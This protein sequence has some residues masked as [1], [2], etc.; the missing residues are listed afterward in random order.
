MTVSDRYLPLA[1]APIDASHPKIAGRTIIDPSA[2]WYWPPAALV[3]DSHGEGSIAELLSG[4]REEGRRK[5]PGPRPAMML[6]WNGGRATLT[7]LRLRETY[8]DAY[9]VGG[10]AFLL[11]GVWRRYYAD[12]DEQSAR[13]L[14]TRDFGSLLQ[15]DTTVVL[16]DDRPMIERRV[17]VDA[18]EIDAP[19]LCATPNEAGH[20][21]LW[22]LHALPLVV[23]FQAHPGRYEKL[24]VTGTNP[25]LQ[26]MLAWLGMRDENLLLHDVSRAY[27][28]RD[29]DRYRESRYFFYVNKSHRR[30]FQRLALRAS[31]AAG[32]P[33]RRIFVSRL[34]HTRSC[35]YRSLLNE[36]AL[37]DA[38]RPLGFE[39]VEPELLSPA[40][41]IRTF[42]GADVVVG[43]GGGAMF[44][45]VFCKP[46]TRVLSIESS[47]THLAAH[48]SLFA[49]LGL[50]YGFL[51]GH[52]D[53]S[54]PR[55]TQKRWA[56]DVEAAAAHVARF[57]AL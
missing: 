47:S 22:L 27:R 26:A 10:D 55:V 40:E 11:D 42:A 20:W 50:R 1:F 35:G 53:L 2:Q 25:N 39:T 45:T 7:Q 12:G 37:I 13:I 17:L 52:E 36:V 33:A 54:D 34:S 5:E 38:L 30:V 46:G 4:E 23:A 21:G 48:A 24:L 56:I 19:T 57:I 15:R 51:L 32:A 3:A 6:G 18:I 44:N 43:L 9:L 49:S 41:Q 29:V 8:R 28:F 14:A 31:Q 16:V